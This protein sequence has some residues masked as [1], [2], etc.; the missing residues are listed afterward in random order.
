[1]TRSSS[2]SAGRRAAIATGWVNAIQ[3]PSGEKTGA[4]VTPE[5]WKGAPVSSSTFTNQIGLSLPARRLDAYESSEPSGL[6]R[7]SLA[8]APAGEIRRA[9]RDPSLGA[10]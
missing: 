4:S 3:R 5:I 9:G 1:M 10:S 7:G 2:V 6:Q 8:L